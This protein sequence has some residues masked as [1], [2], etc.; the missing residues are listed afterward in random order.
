MDLQL[1]GKTVLMTGTESAIGAA[2]ARRLLAEGSELVVLERAGCSGAGALAEDP[3]VRTVA[4]PEPWD[5]ALPAAVAAQAGGVS[6]AWLGD[7]AARL[8]IAGAARLIDAAGK[9]IAGTGGGAMVVQS[10]EAGLIDVP[11][12]APEYSAMCAAL[13]QLVRTAAVR[14]ADGGVQV[15]AVAPAGILDPASG[16]VIDAPAVALSGP[17]DP[18]DVADLAA[19][20]LAPLASYTTGQTI[21]ID[22]GASI[23]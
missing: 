5:G 3:R 19:F 4:L 21:V 2:V 1:A 7:L 9:L 18:A 10:S 15:N 14:L 20:L 13:A 6:L 17:A 8:D 22:G 11:S 23:I 16:A 12:A